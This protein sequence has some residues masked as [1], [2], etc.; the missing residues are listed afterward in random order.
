MAEI[1]PIYQ[2]MI[3]IFNGEKKM[4]ENY[5]EACEFLIAKFLTP[6]PDNLDIQLELIM[7]FKGKLDGSAREAINANRKVTTWPELKAILVHNFGD[8]R[9]ESIMAYDLNNTLPTQGEKIQ[10]YASKVRA[11][12]YALLSK[13]NLTEPDAQIRDIK[14]QQYNDLALQTFLCG[15]YMIDRELT[16]E[17]KVK[18]PPDIETAES[19][20]S[21][22]ENFNMLQNR[23]IR[24]LQKAQPNIKYVQPVHI[25]QQHSQNNYQ[26]PHNQRQQNQHQVHN[27]QRHQQQQQHHQQQQQPFRN[28]NQHSQQQSLQRRQQY[29][30]PAH[31]LP[32][33]QERFAL[34]PGQYHERQT[35]P[36]PMDIDTSAIKRPGSSLQRPHKRPWSAHVM[37]DEEANEEIP[38]DNNVE[39]IDYNSYDYI[40]EGEYN[41]E[42]EEEEEVQ[43]EDT[44]NFMTS[45]PANEET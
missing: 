11:T 15:L 45:A 23:R 22:I 4:L 28:N 25:K 1:K 7:I 12:L 16:Q 40:P 39:S 21:E 43:Y 44:V 2:N 13:I 36:V 24:H 18:S 41:D 8:K 42:T 9:S 30:P 33:A 29:I 35:Q 31:N 5:I 32:R 14:I 38:N 20:A 27:P 37:I 10:H 19:Y 6:D 34:A 26:Q 3:P 17:V